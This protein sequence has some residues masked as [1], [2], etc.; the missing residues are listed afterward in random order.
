MNFTVKVFISYCKFTNRMGFSSE[1]SDVCI[2]KQSVYKCKLSERFLK[3]LNKPFLL[4]R[5]MKTFI[6]VTTVV[7]ESICKR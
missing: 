5:Y 3:I 4:I 6:R 1:I 2:Q 7:S